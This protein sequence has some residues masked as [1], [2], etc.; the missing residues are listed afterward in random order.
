MTA[1]GE[2][3]S[4]VRL[5]EMLGVSPRKYATLS[6]IIVAAEPFSI[7]EAAIAQRLAG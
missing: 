7:H 1:A 2:V 6:R 4:H 3:P 5:A